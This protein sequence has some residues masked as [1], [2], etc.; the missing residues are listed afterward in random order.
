MGTMLEEECEQCLL[1]S[2]LL[3]N[4]SSWQARQGESWRYALSA[5]TKQQYFLLGI[6][7]KRVCQLHYKECDAG[8]F[9]VTTLA[10]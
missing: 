4:E 3:E 10:S 1:L 7:N 9:E 8:A 6:W 5:H 2:L